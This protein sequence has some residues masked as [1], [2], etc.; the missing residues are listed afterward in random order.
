RHVG[1][2]GGSDSAVAH[3]EF[4]GTHARLGRLDAGVEIAELGQEV[5]CAGDIV[6]GLLHGASRPLTRGHGLFDRGLSG[7][8][9]A[10]RFPPPRRGCHPG[11]GGPPPLYR[12]S[13]TGGPLGARHAAGSLPRTLPPPGAWPSPLLRPR[14]LPQR[15]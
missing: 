1:I 2:E 15:G 9:A 4:G 3:V 11:A 12:W 14:A 6:A 5:L 13:R 10:S 7:A 8:N